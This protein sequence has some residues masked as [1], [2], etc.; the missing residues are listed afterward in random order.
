LP[1]GRDFYVSPTL[2]AEPAGHAR[3]GY[4]SRNPIPSQ[5]S[6][7]GIGFLESAHHRDNFWNPADLLCIDGQVQ[8]IKHPGC[9]TRDTSFSILF[10]L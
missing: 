6:G 1:D 4:L 3:V 8:N 9:Y 10:K 5:G 2:H 7:N